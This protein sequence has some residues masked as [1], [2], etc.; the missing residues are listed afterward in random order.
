MIPSLDN[1]LTEQESAWLL[2]CQTAPKI[3]LREARSA[4]FGAVQG[5]F[6]GF[7]QHV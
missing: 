2:P 6:H 3:A 5:G 7:N 4:I 1:F